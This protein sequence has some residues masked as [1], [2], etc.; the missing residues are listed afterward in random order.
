VGRLEGK[1]VLVSGAARRI[2]AADARRLVQ[3][4]AAVML[5][6]ILREP[7]A[8]LADE[9]GERAA[10]TVLDVASA[11]DWAHA[12]AHAEERFGA[13]SGLVNNAAIAPIASLQGTTEA[14]FREAF[15]VNQLGVLLGMQAAVPAL[16]RA[17]GGSIVNMS[18]IAGMA[19]SVGVFAHTATKW[20]VRGMTKAAALEL[21]AD[22]IRVNSVHPGPVITPMTAAFL[23]SAERIPLRR[24]G[25]ADEVAS[26]VVY[27]SPTS[28][29]TRRAPS[30]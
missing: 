8:A 20:A 17:G 12:V 28:R 16:R 10:F 30:T 18:S 5:G 7:G 3:E 23:R 26:L 6:D 24:H 14:Q 27:R 19:G 1:V 25:Q 15:E 29:V 22:G 2:G 9:L 21:A 13:L 4:G 11:A